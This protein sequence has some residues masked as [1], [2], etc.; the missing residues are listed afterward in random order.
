[1]IVRFGY[2]LLLAGLL[3]LLGAFCA[4]T[5]RDLIMIVLGVE[6]MLNASAIAFVG[7]ALH[8]G[9][10]EGQ[11]FVLFALTV[12]AVEISIGLALVVYAFLRKGSFDPS[13]F[14]LLE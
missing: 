8:W 3:F 1:M 2:V 5:R 12:A 7:A 14:N 10:L 6:V 13:R 4:L 9:Q 11:A